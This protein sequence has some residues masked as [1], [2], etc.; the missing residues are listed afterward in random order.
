VVTFRTPTGPTA[1]VAIRDFVEDAGGAAG[2]DEQALLRLSLAVE[3][4]A[5]N[6]VT[7]GYAEAGRQGDIQVQ[8]ETHPG[9]ITVT[10]EDQGI[11]FDPSVRPP[12]SETDLAQP[13]E[14]RLPGGLGLFLA[15][16]SLD[17][18]H[19]ERSHGRNRNILEIRFP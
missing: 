2:L 12:P 18:F 7:H 14:K 17:S 8:V 4:I 16:R 5:Y 9:R 15:L 11:A 3:E 13:L 1:A 6:I 10:L 19:Y